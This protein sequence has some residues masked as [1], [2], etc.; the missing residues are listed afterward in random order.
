MFSMYGR[1]K[2]YFTL[3]TYLLYCTYSFIYFN[4]EE[5]NLQWKAICGSVSII[6]HT[7]TFGKHLHYLCGDN[8]YNRK[9]G[10]LL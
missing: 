4:P 10:Q 2:D 5:K 6:F 9:F 8:L 3:L 1:N 7:D